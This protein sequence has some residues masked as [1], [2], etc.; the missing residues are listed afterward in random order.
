MSKFFQSAIKLTKAASAPSLRFARSKASALVTE[1]TITKY[2]DHTPTHYDDGMKEY[3]KRSNEKHLTKT[4]TGS[5][6]EKLGNI[7]TPVKSV[8]EIISHSAYFA[9]EKMPQ[10][11]EEVIERL[12]HNGLAV[13]IHDG[14]SD[15]KEMY[16]KYSGGICDPDVSKKIEQQL[17]RL[18]I[19]YQ[20]IH[21]TSRVKFPTASDEIWRAIIASPSSPKQ[22]EPKQCN[23]VRNLLAFCAQRSLAELAPDQLE[24]LIDDV[25]ATLATQNN[26]LFVDSLCQ[27]AISKERD[28]E[29]PLFIKEFAQEIQKELFI[30]GLPATELHM[31][32]DGSLEAEMMYEIAKRNGIEFP[33]KSVEET[34]LAYKFENLSDFLNLYFL[35]ASVMKTEKDF[36]DLAYAYLKEA[37]KDGIIHSEMFVGPQTHTVRGVLFDSVLNGTCAAIEHAKKDF[38]ISS[39]LILDFQRDIGRS[40]KTDEMKEKIAVEAAQKTLDELLRWQE[41][42]PQHRDKV[43]GVGLDYQEN[44][45]PPI[46]FREVFKR[47]KAAGLKAT[48]HA[49]EDGPAEYVWQAIKELA[50]D[51][52]D[53]GNRAIEDEDLLYHLA[54]KQIPLTMCPLSNEALGKTDPAKHPLKTMMELGIQATVN[55]D[56]PAYFRGKYKNGYVKGNFSVIAEALD[57]DAKQ[58]IELARNSIKASFLSDERKMEY[59]QEL[60]HYCHRHNE[61]HLDASQSLD[62]KAIPASQISALA[63]H[64]LTKEEV[65]VI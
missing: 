63:K 3:S 47:A 11:V 7:K 50:V 12:N 59:M 38:G 9:Q 57:L 19:Q 36:E 60:D 1:K 2:Q 37:H 62:Q 39:S 17:G 6:L 26:T 30:K 23:E 65:R 54:Q 20:T 18:K 5:L 61:L 53:H 27:I 15:V 42:N 51:R 33:Y 22:D 29:L 56:D 31:H 49:G 8:L 35:G 40:E 45:F 43:V 4:L 16:K 13:F 10:F 28:S 52:I 46:W 41:E 55:S 32:L 64:R 48:C 24:N 25:K 14:K 44:G 34:R 21:F 58:I